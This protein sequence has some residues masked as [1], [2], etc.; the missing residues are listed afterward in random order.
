MSVQSTCTA[1][2]SLKSRLQQTWIKPLNW[3]THSLQRKKLKGCLRR[4][5]DDPESNQ[6]F[7]HDIYKEAI[8][9]F[10]LNMLHYYFVC[11]DKQVLSSPGWCNFPRKVFPDQVVLSWSWSVYNVGGPVD[12]FVLMTHKKGIIMMCWCHPLASTLMIF[13]ETRRILCPSIFDD[14]GPSWFCINYLI[15]LDPGLRLNIKQLVL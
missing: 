6:T 7:A 2:L 1:G 5:C 9:R 14:M 12:Y 11:L 13:N 3:S 8:V 4:R 10:S 15:N